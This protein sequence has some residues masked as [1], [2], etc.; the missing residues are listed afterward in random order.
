MPG[1]MVHRPTGFQVR[2]DIRPQLRQRLGARDHR[3]RAAKQLLIHLGHH[4]RIVISLT[5]EHHPIERL[6]MLVTG[7]Q[8]S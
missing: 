2:S 5:P 8:A 6:Q 4:I 3:R 7:F 1:D